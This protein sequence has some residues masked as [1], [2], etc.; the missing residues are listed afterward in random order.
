M[1]IK[2]GKDEI[3]KI[4]EEIQRIDKEVQSEILERE[5]KQYRPF[6]PPLIKK[7]ELEFPLN[8]LL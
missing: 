1:G 5:E 8:I 4:E 3:R 7:D 6:E 2:F